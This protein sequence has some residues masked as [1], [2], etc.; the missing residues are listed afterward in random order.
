LIIDTDG[1][2]VAGTQ[3]INLFFGSGLRCRARA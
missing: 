1:N 2:R 3:S